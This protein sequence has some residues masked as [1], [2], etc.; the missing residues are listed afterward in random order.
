MVIVGGM[1]MRIDVL[2]DF[3]VLLFVLLLMVFL[4]EFYVVLWC[5]GVVE[6]WGV[7]WGMCCGK[8][9]WFW[10]VVGLVGLICFDLLVYGLVW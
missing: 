9:Y 2:V 6:V 5:V 7:Y 8:V 10:V 3:L 4:L 1:L